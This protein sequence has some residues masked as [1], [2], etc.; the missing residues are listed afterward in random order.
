MIIFMPQF[1]I[2]SDENKMVFNFNFLLNHYK[3]GNLIG[4]D[5][6]AEL[7]KLKEKKLSLN[8]LRKH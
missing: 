1:I 2:F 3:T 8:I 5:I 6:F 4:A 7:F